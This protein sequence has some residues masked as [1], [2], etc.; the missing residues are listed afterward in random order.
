MEGSEHYQASSLRIGSSKLWRNNSI[1]DFSDSFREEDDEESLK[2]AAIEKLPTFARIRTGILAEEG[3]QLRE[4]DIKKLGLLER[5]N[6]VERLVKVADED[7]EK[8]LLRLRERIDQALP[9]L[10]NFSVTMFEGFLNCLH[11][12]PNKKQ[13]LP[14]LK[15]VSGIIKP[16]RMALLLGPPSSGKTTLL[17][18]LAGKL[19]KD[20]KAAAMKGQK[21]SVV[22]DYK[23]KILGLDVCAD[24]LVGDQMIRGISGGQKKRVTT[25]RLHC[26]CNNDI[27]SE[28]KYAPE[29]SNR[30]F[31]KQ[32]LLLLCLN[33]MASGLF[34]LVAAL[35]R[36]MIVANTCTSLALLAIIVMGGFIL[37]RDGVKKWWLWGYWVSPL[38]YAQNSVAVNEFLGKSWRHIPP[39]STER[40]GVLVLKSRGLFPEAHWYWIGVGALIGYTFLFNFL[41]TLALKYL[42]PFS[43]PQAVIS[44]ETLHEVDSLGES[45]ELSSRG[46]KFSEK[47]GESTSSRPPHGKIGSPDGATQPSK[48]GT[49]LPFE[50]YSLT[51]DE[52]RYA[53]DMPQLFLMKRGGEEIYIGPLG[54]HSCHLIKY[55]EEIKGIPKIKDG[56]NPATW[57]LEITS[58]AQEEII[59][60]N[61][62]HIYKNSELYRR[63]KA[64]IKE[65]SSPAPGSNDLHFR[66]RYS[67]PF[68]VQCLASLWKLHW[69][70]WRNPPYTAVRFILTTVIALLLGTIFWDLGSKRT[71]QQDIL[72]AM[73]S[74]YAAVIFLGLQNA[75]SV[76]PVVAVERTVFYREKVAGMYSALPYAFA[77][78]L[79]ELPYTLIQSLI[80]G[81]IVYAM[82]GFEWTAS[83]FF[84][85]LF[86]M[87]FTLLYYTFYGMMT[88]AVT[89]NQ[90]NAAII[91]TFF[92]RIWNIFSG[93]IIPRTRIPVWWRWFYWIC[94][95]SWTLYG[96]A[97]SQFGDVKD[98]FESGET[99]EHFVRSYFGFRSDFLGVVAIVIVGIPVLF[100]FIFAFSIK[101]FNF[102]KR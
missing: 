35:G 65:L 29:F 92:Y 59:G 77:Q 5:R 67:Q 88:V 20:L 19:S 43:K 94:P 8:F 23:L 17:L 68:V 82:I 102:Q 2:W 71:Q 9:T 78:V 39:N 81:V 25:A 73:G 87:Y 13:P 48:G 12:L 16:Q 28:S 27:V 56:Y 33:Q 41:F 40:L 64:L 84:W 101:T 99:V 42:N 22:T 58:A 93:F 75:I 45:V 66:T 83:K 31:F 10:F 44:K 60:I 74:M 30:W 7:H 97:A 61:F 15:D 72:N 37:S 32:Y 95:V 70:Y 86:F 79:I 47:G 54:R 76:Q 4:V 63:N 1:E 69:S 14:I 91:S 50:P 53:V 98:A 80:Y 55:F 51:F 6:L 49:V 57:M 18:A 85:Y 62:T 36:N 26:F 89:P 34:R 96:L 3:G 24:T 90:H 38:M 11:I 100:A 46:K 52:I 21:A